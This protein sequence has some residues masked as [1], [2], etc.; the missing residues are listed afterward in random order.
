VKT[1]IAIASLAA[2]TL[3]AVVIAATDPA[4]ADGSNFKPVNDAAVLKE[5]GACHM[6][7]PAGLLPAR[8]WAAIMTGLKDHFG[9]NAELD[10]ETARRIGDYLAAN[11]A[12]S[13]G[14]RTEASRD[15]RQGAAPLRITELPWWRRKHEKKGRVAPETLK[16]RGAKLKS[17]CVACHADAARGLFD[18]D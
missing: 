10:A 13:R 8:S 2:G 5:C 9:E 16:R 18:D 17:D 6:A 11:A 4:V 14:A 3:A 15:L 1:L 12:D 7:Y